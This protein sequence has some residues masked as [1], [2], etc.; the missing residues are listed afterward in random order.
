MA[1]TKY[2]LLGALALLLLFGCVNN[3]NAG[4]KAPNNSLDRIGDSDITP[5]NSG[6]ELTLPSE[7]NTF[8]DSSVNE[9]DVYVENQSSDVILAGEDIIIEPG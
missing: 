1:Q 2:I 9:T 4:S 8:S 5:Q 7:S 6:T 3:Q